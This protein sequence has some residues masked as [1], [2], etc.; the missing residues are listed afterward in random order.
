ME[1]IIVPI[2]NITKRSNSKDKEIHFCIQPSDKT[3]KVTFRIIIPSKLVAYQGE[4]T[5][6]IL[7]DQAKKETTEND[8]FILI[9]TTLGIPASSLSSSSLSPSSSSS[10]SSSDFNVEC[11]LEEEE[12]DPNNNNNNV[13]WHLNLTVQ[14]SG[15]RKFLHKIPIKKECTQDCLEHLLCTVKNLK[16]ELSKA[17]VKNE[18]LE[19]SNEKLQEK[20]SELSTEYKRKES[21]LL[22]S[23]LVL[24]NRKKQKVHELK[25]K[26]LELEKSSRN[27]KFSRQSNSDDDDIDTDEERNLRAKE[28]EALGDE[29]EDVGGSSN[30]LHP[31]PPSSLSSHGFSRNGNHISGFTQFR[32]G[33]ATMMA[34]TSEEFLANLSESDDENKELSHGIPQAPVQITKSKRK[35]NSKAS[36]RKSANDTDGKEIPVPT[37]KSKKKGFLSK[38]TKKCNDTKLDMHS[39]SDDDDDIFMGL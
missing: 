7:K 28:M 38:K 14:L 20:Y 27:S 25:Q 6:N 8:F 22:T 4:I 13:L 35:R 9:K 2:P 17:L 32:R 39:S 16:D 36:K 30:E 19:L 11:S 10:S 24:L 29:D 12:E 26:L 18:K 23:F 15:N 33:E 5:Y 37:K 1:W 21:Q 3:K 34:L 31:P